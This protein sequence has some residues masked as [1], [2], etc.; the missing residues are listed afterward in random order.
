MLDS[1]Y[2]II[3]RGING[4][5]Y[6]VIGCD[7]LTMIHQEFNQ[8]LKKGYQ[9]TLVSRSVMLTADNLGEARAYCG[10]PQIK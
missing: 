7:K 4:R 9:V 1:R 5:F 8:Y 2:Y 10:L 3:I 6:D